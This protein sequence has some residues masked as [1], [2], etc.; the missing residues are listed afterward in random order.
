MD[1]IRSRDLDAATARTLEL[2]EMAAHAGP[3]RSVRDLGDTIL[4]ADPLDADPFVNRAS[5]LR[6]PADPRGFD[7]RL[8]QLVVLFATLDRR[9]H[10]WSSPLGAT[11]ADLPRRLL[12]N[13]FALM[14]ESRVMAVEGAHWSVPA[15]PV[16]MHVR[17]VSG[18][19]DAGISAACDEAAAILAA[20]FPGA[21]ADRLSVELA[22]SLGEA[23]HAVYL[24]D[25]RVDGITQPVA[26]ARAYAAGGLTYLSSIGTLPEWRGRGIA[27]GLVAAAAAG[28]VASGA[29]LTYLSVESG[30]EAAERAYARIGFRPVGQPVGRFLAS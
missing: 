6:F 13:G 17:C 9:P 30:N 11:P 27:G 15:M 7:E 2:H 10:V 20:V 25:A 26:V 29:R 16:G 1:R 14:G 4:L 24:A 23:G 3:R 18:P 22:A 28:G 5:A 21:D 19:G 12:A 8:D